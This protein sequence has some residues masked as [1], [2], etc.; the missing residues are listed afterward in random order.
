MQHLLN[1]KENATFTDRG[2]V[3]INSLRLGQAVV[4]QNPLTDQEK[5]QL[6]VSLFSMGIKLF[7][8]I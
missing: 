5:L 6:K 7:L 3:T 2:T 8:M 4:N 1:N